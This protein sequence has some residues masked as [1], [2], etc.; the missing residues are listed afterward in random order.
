MEPME[1]M[2]PI[3]QKEMEVLVVAIMEQLHQPIPIMQ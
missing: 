3:E 1:L 2:H